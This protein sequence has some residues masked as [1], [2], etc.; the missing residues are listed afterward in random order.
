MP[1]TVQALLWRYSCNIMVAAITST[2]FLS[3][4]SFF[5]MPISIIACFASFDVYLSSTVF[6]GIA[7]NSFRN[8]LIAS[9]TSG[10]ACVSDSSQFFGSPMII[11][12]TSFSEKYFFK[13]GIISFDSIVVKPVPIILNGSVT[14]R[15]VRFPP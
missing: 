12:S 9:F 14:A 15:P 7:G 3:R 13:N 8:F 10:V 5:F 1:L 11:N 2:F 4:R 6:N